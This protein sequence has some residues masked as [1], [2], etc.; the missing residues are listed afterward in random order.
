MIRTTVFAAMLAAM[1]A[2]PAQAGTIVGTKAIADI[3]A[4]SADSGDIFTA[5]SFS[6]G[7][8][9]AAVGGTLDFATYAPGLY[10][11]SATTLDLTNITTFTIGNAALGSF[12]AS[13][14]VVDAVGATSKSFLIFGNFTPG[15]DFPG[16]LKDTSPASLAI[17]F[18]QVSGPGGTISASGTLKS[19]EAVPE[20]T[21]LA[22]M[23]VGLFTTG[24]IA[25]RRLTRA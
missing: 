23:G 21:S 13:S 14:F 3:G 2:L 25:R 7:L 4:T 15:T 11:L 9:V 16:S 1:A 19:P 10:F 18:T 20:P 17:G 6:F 22:L 8:P 12:T 24:L 5:T